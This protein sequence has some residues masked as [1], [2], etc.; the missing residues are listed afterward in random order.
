MVVKKLASA[1]EMQIVTLL[2]FIAIGAL[3]LAALR[4]FKAYLEKRYLSILLYAS[5]FTVVAATISIM[6]IDMFGDFY[7]IIDGRIEWITTITNSWLIPL[8]VLLLYLGVTYSKQAS[9]SLRHYLLFV[10]I[11]SAMMTPYIGY[12]SIERLLY[13]LEVIVLIMVILEISLYLIKMI[14]IVKTQSHESVKTLYIFM[15]GII[16]F[17]ASGAWGLGINL[18][19]LPYL[20]RFSWLI[21][22]AIGVLF[23]TFAISRNYRV[24]YISEARPLTLIILKYDTT[25]LFTYEFEK[26]S[27]NLDPVLVSGAISGIISLLSE[28]MHTKTGLN[29]IDYESNKILLEYGQHTIGVLITYAESLVL[30]YNLKRL[31]KSIE[32]EYGDTLQE[33]KEIP[34]ISENINALIPKIF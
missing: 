24:L 1:F 20:M 33:T 8:G 29:R 21:V 13:A 3:S 9:L 26:V 22:N 5:A 34:K 10:F 7:I 17:F 27:E 30:R 15:T 16:L 2:H 6:T 18:L 12:Y 14:R 4:S 19:S 31:I 23:M 11:G 25:T 28:I 32:K